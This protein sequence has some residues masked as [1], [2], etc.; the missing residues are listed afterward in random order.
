MKQV[1]LDCLGFLGLGCLSYGL[2]LQFGVAVMLM[3]DGILLLI[4]SLLV[5][6][7]KVKYDQFGYPP[8]PPKNPVKYAQPP[9]RR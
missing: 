6:K 8:K 1:F 9:K 7:N 3:S 5:T 4:F 2:C